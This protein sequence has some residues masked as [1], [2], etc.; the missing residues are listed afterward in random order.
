[1]LLYTF[2]SRGNSYS[3]DRKEILLCMDKAT[4]GQK[5]VVC[6]VVALPSGVGAV[7]PPQ[8]SALEGA[9]DLPLVIR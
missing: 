4:V 6:G 3:K 7:Y 2:V 9:A 8:D 5:S 1:M